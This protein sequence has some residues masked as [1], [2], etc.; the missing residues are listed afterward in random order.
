MNFNT[1]S[2]HMKT[3]TQTKYLFSEPN[4]THYALNSIMR[5][6]PEFNFNIK[7]NSE[8][9]SFYTVFKIMKSG[10]LMLKKPKQNKPKLGRIF[11]ITR[12]FFLTSS[13]SVI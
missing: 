1:A 5:I 4:K 8:T 6:I 10:I 2:S 9:N 11:F 7:C 3:K 13:I 12:F